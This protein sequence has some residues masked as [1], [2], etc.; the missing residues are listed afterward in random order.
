MSLDKENKIKVH[1]EQLEL[2]LT[3][4]DVLKLSKQTGIFW[5]QF[6]E[7]LES[8]DLEFIFTALEIASKKKL[9]LN[10]GIPANLPEIVSALTLAIMKTIERPKAKE[11]K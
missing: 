7:H 6:Y 9:D 3:A 10:K 4:L 1:D 11:K 2:N 5:G 8:G